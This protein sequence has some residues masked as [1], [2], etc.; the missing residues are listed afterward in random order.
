MEQS[1]TESG[2]RDTGLEIPRL[3]GMRQEA[4]KILSPVP[5][6]ESKQAFDFA[7]SRDNA[8]SG[9]LAQYRFIHFAT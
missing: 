8:T 6:S 7:A 9:D 5:Q 1:L 2:M 4:L 3:P